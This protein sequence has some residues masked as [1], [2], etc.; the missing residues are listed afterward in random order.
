MAFGKIFK[1]TRRRASGGARWGGLRIEPYKPNAVDADGDGIVQEGTAWERP[2]GT[3]IINLFGEEI[4]EGRISSNRPLDAVV[5]DSSGARVDYKPT[6]E[7]KPQTPELDGSPK[8]LGPKLGD[9]LPAIGQTAPPLKS[10]TPTIL[11]IKNPPQQPAQ[12]PE[13]VA[14][15]TPTLPDVAPQPLQVP[16]RDS[17]WNVD[18]LFEIAYYYDYTISPKLSETVNAAGF[19]KDPSDQPGNWVDR[20]VPEVP[21]LI[22]VLSMVRGDNPVFAARGSSVL[23]GGGDIEDMNLRVHLVT[24]DGEEKIRLLF[25]LTDWAGNSLARNAIEETG[26]INWVKGSEKYGK[27]LKIRR[28]DQ[29]ADGR[30]VRSPHFL[31]NFR[32][33]DPRVG[34]SYFALGDDGVEYSFHRANTT[35]DSPNF[36]A[37]PMEEQDTRQPVAWHNFVEILFP[38]NATPDDIEN[39]LRNAGVSDARPPS[40][41]Q[42]VGVA[43]N[44]L[45]RYLGGKTDG[46]FNYE[47]E[48]R[49]TI[50]KQI[51]KDFGLTG[52]DVQITVQGGKNS[53]TYL[54]PEETAKKI[55]ELAGVRVFT[56]DGNLNINTDLPKERFEN[57]YVSR[58]LDI[59]ESGA[60][61][62]T[63]SR[64]LNGLNVMGASSST[65]I[66]APGGDGV[67]TSP[68]K[69]RGIEDL[70]LEDDP[71]WGGFTFFFDPVKLFQ[72]MDWWHNNDD[73]YGEL[74]IEPPLYTVSSDYSNPHDMGETVFKQQLPFTDIIDIRAS[75]ERRERLLQAIREKAKESE[76]LNVFADK[77]EKTLIASREKAAKK[78][79]NGLPSP[80]QISK[81][82]PIDG[83]LGSQGGK[84][85]RDSESGSRY[86]VKPAQS[87]KHAHNELSAQAIY[88]YFGIDVDDTGIYEEG[89][90]W[91]IVKKAILG[92]NS[93]L[94]STVGDSIIDG[95]FL[96][97]VQAQARKGFAADVL[98][99]SWDVYGLDGDNVVLDGNGRLY[100]IDL[101]GSLIYRAMGGE[102]TSFHQN[103]EW[104]EPWTMRTS[105]QGL[106]M[107]GKITDKEAA[108]LLEPMFRLDLPNEI[109]SLLGEL[110]I[111]KEVAEHIVMTFDAR[112]RRLWNVISELRR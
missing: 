84:W 6:Y 38:R 66:Y 60:L 77:I 40:K 58:L 85:Y 102:K 54:L 32:V 61:Y 19:T 12:I 33:D 107:Y 34:Q 30:I 57:E 68:K 101:G 1:G 10:I 7:D 64:W 75:P 95:E 98:M 62:S 65:D 16:E 72:R 36:F 23:A 91:F 67:F 82:T 111:D 94:A 78:L 9:N 97:S 18:D 43:E 100:R 56:H 2:A 88:R 31:L 110:K 48:S 108:D 37:S 87:K 71:R 81:M 13:T 53:I 41:S 76:E 80:Q 20:V 28:Y 69:N 15:A 29:E 96:E 70:G 79:L 105:E 103:G 104:V 74:S 42:I 52:E 55:S 14:E 89:G 99:S 4:T 59:I 93:E 25:R 73:L 49:K 8:A 92:E 112:I 83:P 22:E 50:L 24:S 109:Y 106:Q 90:R 11:E 45:I 35:A 63:A 3:R 46:T 17:D 86:L 26:K 21:S 47:G 5:V 27:G 39:A 51:E 44:K